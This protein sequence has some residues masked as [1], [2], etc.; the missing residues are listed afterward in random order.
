MG[1]DVGGLGE[2]NGVGVLIGFVD[3]KRT[4]KIHKLL[5]NDIEILKDKT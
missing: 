1:G 5:R 4:K 3:P 2:R